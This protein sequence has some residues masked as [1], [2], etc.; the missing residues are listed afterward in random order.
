ME[1]Q[2]FVEC[3]QATDHLDEN[4]P[5]VLLLDV[6]LVFLVLGDLL[7]QVTVITVLHHNAKQMRSKNINENR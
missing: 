5:N 1:D 4:A 7:E 3:S 2:S 6:L